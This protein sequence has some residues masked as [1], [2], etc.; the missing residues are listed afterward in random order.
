MARIREI[1]RRIGGVR[2]VQRITRT[3]QMIA[4]AKFTSAVQKVSSARPYSERIDRLVGEALAAAGGE[5][6]H[7]LVDGPSESPSRERVL[8][9]TSNRGMCGAYNANALR[10]AAAHIRA[11]RERGREL[12][13]ETAGK[14]AVGY[15]RFQKIP[16][17]VSHAMGDEPR[18]D[19]IERLATTYIE[20]FT[21]GRH[22]AVHVVCMRYLSTSRQEPRVIRLLPLAPP[23]A[24]GAGAEPPAGGGASALYDF[25]PSVQSILDQLMPVAVKTILFQAFLESNVSEQIMRMVAMK[26]ATENA[27]DLVRTLTRR[28]NR[29]RQTQ[30][31]TELM[32]IISGAAALE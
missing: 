19:E 18:Y 23:V 13:L 8:V 14:K 29:A 6:E 7:P 20:D 27:G 25:S 12:D 16:V 28:F 21:A 1:K 4:T 32:E 22:D 3:M 5:F 11:L 31:T 15:F 24:S 17:T 30:I 10:T 2:T 9:I 26:A